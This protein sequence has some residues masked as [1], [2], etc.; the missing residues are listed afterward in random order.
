M[1]FIIILTICAVLIV[2]CNHSWQQVALA[3]D[4]EIQRAAHMQNFY[5]CEALLNYGKILFQQAQL[6]KKINQSLRIEKTL[7]LYAGLWPL[8]SL[9]NGNNNMYGQLEAKF[10]LTKKKWYLYSTLLN[11]AQHPQCQI[12]CEIEVANQQKLKFK[13]W[14]QRI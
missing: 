7:V 5:R 11:H 13:N 4:L 14:Q 12:S 2:G 6:N 1:N 9:N 10:N 3:A 8:P